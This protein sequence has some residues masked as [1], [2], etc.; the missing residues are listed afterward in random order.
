MKSSTR[1]ILNELTLFC[2]PGAGMTVNYGA[3]ENIA[4]FD[5]PACCV[6]AL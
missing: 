2:I 3:Q 4:E 1:R 5:P 6:E